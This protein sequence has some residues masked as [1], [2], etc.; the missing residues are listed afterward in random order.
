LVVFVDQL[1]RV[2][3]H[4]DLGFR[5]RDVEFGALVAG[6]G[7]LFNF[8]AFAQAQDNLA[9][10]EDLIERIAIGLEVFVVG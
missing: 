4:V 10:Q 2:S 1:F 7:H 8:G 5:T 6:G 9:D 3:F